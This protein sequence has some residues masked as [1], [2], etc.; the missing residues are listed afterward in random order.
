MKY[1]ISYLKWELKNE[2]K[3]SG[4]FAAM[5]F[6]YGIVEWIYGE[7]QIS[8]IVS[9][10][11]FLLNWLVSTIQ[12]L[13]LDEDKEYDQKTY[14]KRAT[15]LTIFSAILTVV[16][17]HGFG[18]FEKRSIYAELFMYVCMVSAYILVWI[19]QRI[20]QNIDTKQLNEQ[21]AKYKE[22]ELKEEEKNGTCN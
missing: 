5:L 10:E 13:V 17:C 9:V 21:L 2:F 14:V 3:A 1:I 19:F 15:W 8:M 20:A 12:K 16:C 7:Q 18:W 11:M 22:K 6:C 4:Y